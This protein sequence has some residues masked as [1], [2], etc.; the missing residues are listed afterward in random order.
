MDW[1]RA[2][3]ILIL[4]FLSLDVLL[5]L[6]WWQERSGAAWLA[7][8]ASTARARTDLAAL[9]IVLSGELPD[10]VPRG[11]PLLQAHARPVDPDQLA[12]RFF[13]G[14]GSVGG[15]SGSIGTVGGGSGAAGTDGAQTGS[16]GTDGA[17]T[18]GDAASGRVFRRGGERLTV[19][20]QGLVIYERR[21]LAAGDVS[22]SFDAEAARRIAETFLRDRAALPSDAVLDHVLPTTSGRPSAYQVVYVRRFHG[23]PVYDSYVGVEVVGAAVRAMESFWPDMAFIGEAL[24]IIGAE[25][26]LRALAQRLSLHPGDKLLV[27]RV[28]LGYYGANSN[29]RATDWQAVPVWRVLTK[30]GKSFY[31]NAYLGKLEDSA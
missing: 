5:A 25:D 24:P 21:D 31:I 9:G 2:K 30:D 13:N 1:R 3:T 26:A 12:A 18:G 6:R 20:P 22:A 15:G 8:P 7:A 28:E 23:W 27:E 4:A 17:R 10:R 11:M 29:L 16:I 19:L 14:G